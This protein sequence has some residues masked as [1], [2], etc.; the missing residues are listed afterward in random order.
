[1]QIVGTVP[2]TNRME[3]LLLFNSTVL[4]FLLMNSK[5]VKCT[6]IVIYSNDCQLDGTSSLTAKYF[7]D[8]LINFMNNNHFLPLP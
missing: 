7:M 5:L 1:M 2:L 8:R 4:N 6:P 3:K